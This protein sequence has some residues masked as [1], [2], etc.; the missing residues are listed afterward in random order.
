M[1]PYQI[2]SCIFFPEDS[3]QTLVDKY[4]FIGEI[5]LVQDYRM[6]VQWQRVNDM[7]RKQDEENYN[8]ISIASKS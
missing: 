8:S 1:Y 5:K 6:N 3:I 4:D 7:Y 2:I